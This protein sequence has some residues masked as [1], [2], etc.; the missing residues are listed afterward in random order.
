MEKCFDDGQDCSS[1]NFCIATKRIDLH[2][3]ESVSHS[4]THYHRK[5]SK[6]IGF[7][8]GRDKKLKGIYVSMETT[9]D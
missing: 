4:I 8:L 9:Q 2:D 3:C 1:C 6:M 5:V 7:I